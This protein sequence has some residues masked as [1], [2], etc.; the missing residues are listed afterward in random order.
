[1]N[2]QYKFG[3]KIT[4]DGKNGLVVNVHEKSYNH[5]CEEYDI[6]VL[7]KSEV[8]DFGQ[9]RSTMQNL[10]TWMYAEQFSDGWQG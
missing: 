4:Y 2:K 7:D 9:L 5:S 6:V 1:M 3:D 10:Y 8:G